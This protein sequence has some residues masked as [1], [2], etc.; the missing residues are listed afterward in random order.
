MQA[1]KAS[2]KPKEILSLATCQ[3]DAAAHGGL[4]LSTSYQTNRVMMYWQCAKGHEFQMILRNVRSGHW[5]PQC[6]LKVKTLQDCQ[7]HAEKLGGKCLSTIYMNTSTLMDWQC[8]RGHTWKA[9]FNNIVACHWCKICRRKMY[10]MEDLHA[11][12]AEY[13][14]K[15]LSDRYM[16]VDNNATWQ[17]AKGHIWDARWGHIAHDGNWCRKCLK[18]RGEEATEAILKAKEVQYE[19][20]RIFDDCPSSKNHRLRF[21]FYL[22]SL[23]VL[24]EFDGAQHFREVEYFGGAEGFQ[25]RVLHDL[26]KCEY[27]V[28]NKITLIRIAFDESLEEALPKRLE[29]A[30]NRHFVMIPCIPK[31]YE[32]TLQAV[33][34]DSKRYITT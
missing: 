20:E 29:E 15:C 14:G 28:D 6:R 33:F 24:I 7:E 12:A 4:C 9:P 30:K 32:G 19:R 17:C 23:N 3:R 2:R 5:C 10:S 22:E 26:M 8:D 18:S 13:G 16:G 21:D 34:D 11:K 1:K 25:R 31:E 27:C